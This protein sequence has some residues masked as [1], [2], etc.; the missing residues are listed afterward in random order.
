LGSEQVKEAFAKELKK[1]K[2]DQEIKL[3]DT[4]CHDFCEMGPLVI[5]YPEG[6]FYV[7]VTPEDVPDIVEE[8][9]INGKVVDRLLYKEAVKEDQLPKYKDLDFYKKQRRVALRNCGSID[10]ERLD[11]YVARDGYASLE[12]ALFEFTPEQVIDEVKRS[13]LRGRGGGGFPT[14]L[15]WEF[16]HRSPG[17]LKYLICNADEGDP[18]AFMANNNP[19]CIR[20]LYLTVGDTLSTRTLNIYQGFLFTHSNTASLINNNLQIAFINL[21]ENGCH[22]ILCSGSNTAGSHPDNDLDPLSITS[23]NFLFGFLSE[24]FKIFSACYFHNFHLAS[25]GTRPLPCFNSTA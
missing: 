18:G 25:T 8:H 14:G 3:G 24:F 1:Q 12:K 13:G 20:R 7:R 10:P 19:C 15:K 5:V 4:D 23:R 17:D 11:E 16:C 2:V 21:F 22:Y 6:T 9:L